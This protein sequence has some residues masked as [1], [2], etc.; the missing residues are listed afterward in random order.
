ML[1]P[2][3]VKFR[4]VHRGRKRGLSRGQQHVEFGD[5]GLKALE[6][7]WL[8]NRQ[9]EAA[10]IAI[11]RKI[12]RGGKVWINVYPDKP[13]TQKPLET[14]MG[15]GKGSPERHVAVIEP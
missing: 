6:A 5:Y 14:R 3:R 8:P 10:R 12:K 15:S 2:K 11:T 4:R 1:S 13:V 9:I 7:G